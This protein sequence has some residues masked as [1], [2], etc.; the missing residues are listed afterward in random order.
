MDKG[1]FY[2]TDSPQNVFC[3]H[4]SLIDKKNPFLNVILFETESSK[5]SF[6]SS[7]LPVCFK[8]QWIDN[9]ADPTEFY[10]LKPLL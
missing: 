10:L 7:F 2:I 1:C 6:F 3:L 9:H 5:F 4:P 8:N